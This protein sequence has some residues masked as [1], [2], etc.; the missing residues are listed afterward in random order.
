MRLVEIT[1]LPRPVGNSLFQGM[2]FSQGQAGTHAKL[3]YHVLEPPDHDPDPPPD[4]NGM[5]IRVL[6]CSTDELCCATITFCGLENVSVKS[7]DGDEGTGHPLSTLGLGMNRFYE[8]VDES[9][10]K[11]A[12]PT[13]VRDG[14]QPPVRRFAFAF[15]TRV[16][17][18]TTWYHSYSVTVERRSILDALR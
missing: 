11:V 18:I 1:D 9:D 17:E 14:S 6:N 2:V 5:R 7:W 16:F 13:A 8:V 10:P 12:N 15:R 4:S 3:S